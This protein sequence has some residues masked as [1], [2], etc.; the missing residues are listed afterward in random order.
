MGLKFTIYSDYINTGLSI[1]DFLESIVVKNLAHI[2]MDW[3]CF[4]CVD[5]ALGLEEVA[6]NLI[7]LSRK[8]SRITCSS[9]VRKPFR[10]FLAE[11]VAEIISPF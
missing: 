6:K 7:E 11:Q 9:T 4:N 8:T 3:R 10:M 1:P 5:K 2:Y